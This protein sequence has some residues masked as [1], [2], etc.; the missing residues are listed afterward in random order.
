MNEIDT[1]QKIQSDIKKENG[2]QKYGAAANDVDA[3][4]AYNKF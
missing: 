2:N 1:S 3:V 4:T